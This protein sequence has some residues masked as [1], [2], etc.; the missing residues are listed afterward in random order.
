M[1]EYGFQGFPDQ[2]TIRKFTAPGDRSIGSPVMKAHQKHPAGYETIDEFMLR[3]YK[4]PKDFE[5][6]GYVSQLLQAGG[7]Q[8]AIEAHRRG[9]PWCMGTLYWQ[10]NDCW[11][12]VSWSSRDYYGKK[13][14]L[15]YLLPRIYANTLVSPTAANGRVRVFIVSDELFEQKGTLTVKLLDFAGNVRSEKQS[16]VV[17]PPLT[18]LVY[19]DTLQQSLIAGMDPNELM[20][21]ATFEGYTSHGD[22]VRAENLLFF[23]PPKDLKLP[24]P[25]ISKK[26]IETKNGYIIQLTCD[27]LVKNLWLSTSVKGD[28]SDNY[29]D[30]L[31][32]TRAEIRFTTTKRDPKMSDLIVV[33][34]LVDTF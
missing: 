11:P 32:G 15:Q 13:K 14:A 24:V 9:R 34:S 29:F 21:R 6:Y 23:G 22:N 8:T 10:L 19:F 31:P 7:I 16:R 30:L 25:V 3:D 2:S 5:S 33:K 18:S 17:I 1:S 28:F 20:L 27:K 12:V 4:K 26:V